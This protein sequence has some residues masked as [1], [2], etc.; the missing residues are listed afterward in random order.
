M[1]RVRYFIY[2]QKCKLEKQ[3]LIN[4]FLVGGNCPCLLIRTQVFTSIAVI[5]Y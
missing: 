4:M 3:Q 1:L 2:N 5:E